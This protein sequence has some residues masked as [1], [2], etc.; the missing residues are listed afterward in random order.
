MMRAYSKFRMLLVTKLISLLNLGPR[1][2]VAALLCLLSVTVFAAPKATV[3]DLAWMQGAWAGDLG[4]NRLEERWNAPRGGTLASLVRM[5]G[6][7]GTSMIE[8]IVIEEEAGSLVLRLQQW[9][10]GFKPRTEG[11]QVFALESLGKK[12]VSWKALG[13][14]GLQSLTYS[15]QG[16]RKFQVDGTTEDGSAFTAKL[17]AVR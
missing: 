12:T 8:L 17:R 16:K 1:F 6:P 9:N 2:T 15:R 14:T 10:P 4:P 3:D 7:T 5:T 11:P 13:S